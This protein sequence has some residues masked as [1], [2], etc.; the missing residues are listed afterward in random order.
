[1]DIDFDIS[2]EAREAVTHDHDYHLKQVHD[3]YIYFL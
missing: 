3:F 1:M 2:S